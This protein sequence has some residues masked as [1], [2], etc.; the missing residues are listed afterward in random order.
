MSDDSLQ[1]KFIDID[2]LEMAYHESGEGD[3]IV[4]LHGNPTSSYLWRNIIPYI[5]TYGRCI[6]PDLPGMG[7]S[8]KL[9]N[10]DDG[11]YRFVEHRY[12]LEAFLNRLGIDNNIIFILHDWGSALGFDWAYRH[13]DSIKGI[14]YMESIVRPALWSDLTEKFKAF[15]IDLRSDKGDGMI[16]QNNLFIETLLPSLIIRELSN[17]EMS[18]YRLP[19][20]QTGESRRPMLTWP[21]EIPIEGDPSDT[22]DI[23]NAYSKWLPDTSIPKL[24]INADPGMI[25]TGER[26]KFC[27]SWKNQEEFT[28][29][30]LHYLQEDSPDEIGEGIAAWLGKYFDVT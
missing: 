11:S 25:L 27:R 1:K 18:N 4:F 14:V 5:R 17:T 20:L 24:F 3:P 12:Y 26:R 9:I 23:I 21:R 29:K 19:Y 10:S 30:G 13:S 22:Y 15:L 8:G 6:A 7:E 2:G 16:L 28:V